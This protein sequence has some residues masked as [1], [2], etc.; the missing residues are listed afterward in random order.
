MNSE[1]V[2]RFLGY[3]ARSARQV[4]VTA[5]CKWMFSTAQNNL[6]LSAPSRVV[7]RPR[8]LKHPVGLRAMSSDPFV[9]RQIMI[10]NEYAPLANLC[11]ATILDLGAN[12]GLASAYFLSRFQDA[13]VLAVE[14]EPAN[15]AACRENLAPYHDR[16]R[17]MHGAVWSGRGPLTLYAKSC[18]ADFRVKEAATAS[19]DDVVVEGWD[20]GSL[21]AMSG[22][23]HID[24]LKIDIEGAEEEIFS[25]GFDQWLPSV[26]NLCIELHGERCRSAFFAAMQ[27]YDYQ[28]A[29][30][31][32]LDI[33]LNI[34]R[35]QDVSSARTAVTLT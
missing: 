4:G 18:A 31:G 28:H 2:Y 26:K 35:K 27:N 32:E 30:S 1:Q 34:R 25:R 19:A 9:F 12:V 13:R 16:A 6:H 15:F 8:F 21:I 22:F 24:L 5:G 10:E 20:V 14:A 3:C 17:V 29:Q 33:C 11:P 23:E 7:L